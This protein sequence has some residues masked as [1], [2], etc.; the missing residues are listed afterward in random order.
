MPC[1]IWPSFTRQDTTWHRR[2]SVDAGSRPIVSTGETQLESPK[3]NCPEAVPRW[4]A[5]PIICKA[6]GI[7]S[8]R[9]VVDLAREGEQIDKRSRETH[10]SHMIGAT[11]D[12]TAS[13]L[14][15]W[16]W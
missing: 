1:F 12:E 8:T 6:G 9:Q 5:S 2:A 3:S 4:L 14:K 13:L 7:W 11:A 10:A 16:L 15:G